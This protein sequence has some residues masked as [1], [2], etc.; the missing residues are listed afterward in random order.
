MDKNEFINRIFKCKLKKANSQII[1]YHE[2]IYN[3]WKKEVSK[4]KKRRFPKFNAIEEPG[5][6][7]EHL[8]MEY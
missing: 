1:D 7:L 5:F 6:G 2:H 8:P 4:S 3:Y